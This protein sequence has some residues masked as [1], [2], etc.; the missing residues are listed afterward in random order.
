MLTFLF[1]W[2][3]DIPGNA[4]A[5]GISGGV[6]AL[7]EVVIDLVKT[8]GTALTVLER[9][10]LEATGLGARFLLLRRHGYVS[11]ADL[12]VDFYRRLLLHQVGDLGVN[13]QRGY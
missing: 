2:C 12:A 4:L 11:F 7:P 5:V 9:G 1:G 13:V 8:A 6:L 3:I 10:W